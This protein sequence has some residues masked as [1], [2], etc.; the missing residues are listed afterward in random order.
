VNVAT[1]QLCCERKRLEDK[2]DRLRMLHTEAVRDKSTTENKSRNLLEK[3]G[4]LEKENESLGHRLSEEKDVADQVK[5]EFQA[6]HPE[7]QAA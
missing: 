2:I 5:L 7:G 3:V 4:F 1:S 6:A